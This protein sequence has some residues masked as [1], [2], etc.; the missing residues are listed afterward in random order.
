MLTGL[1]A[2]ARKIEVQRAYIESPI[3]SRGPLGDAHGK[4]ARSRGER[5]AHIG[6]VH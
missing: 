5:R 3:D 2:I 6:L 4:W 1:I